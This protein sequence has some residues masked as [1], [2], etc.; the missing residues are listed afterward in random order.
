M[1]DDHLPIPCGWTGGSKRAAMVHHRIMLAIRVRG[2]LQIQALETGTGC[3]KGAI[4]HLYFDGCV[5]YEDINEIDATILP[6]GA[7]IRGAIRN[8]THLLQEFLIEAAEEQRVRQL[9]I[10]VPMLRPGGDSPAKSGNERQH[11]GIE[12]DIQLKEERERFLTGDA[13]QKSMLLRQYFTLLL[14]LF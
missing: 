10:V 6:S 1:S 3:G 13:Y 12:K 7:G 2:N 11:T 14:P 9:A 4:K 8:A 5:G